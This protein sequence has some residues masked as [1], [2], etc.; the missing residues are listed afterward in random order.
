MQDDV[1]DILSQLKEH[2]T[3]IKKADD[4]Q[5]DEP[6]VKKFLITK[7]GTLV[8]SAIDSMQSIQ[9][10]LGQTTDA[11]EIMALAKLIEASAKAIDTLNT[12]HNAQERN[13]TSKEVK[14]MEIDARERMNREDNDAR[15]NLVFNR[16]DLIRVLAEPR[17]VEGHVIEE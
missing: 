15:K 14:Q 11:D 13:K 9:Q 6:D 3:E 2:T 10:G 12:L 7:T 5:L 1:D 8:Q 16:E 4:I 17:V